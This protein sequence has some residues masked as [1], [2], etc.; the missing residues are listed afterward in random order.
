MGDQPQCQHVPPTF[1]SACAKIRREA[2]LQLNQLGIAV[3]PSLRVL[4]S[5][6]HSA[7]R[8]GCRPEQEAIALKFLEKVQSLNFA[9]V[10]EL[11]DVVPL[12]ESIGM[13]EAIVQLC[14]AK[15]DALV[16]PPLLLLIC[17]PLL[18]CTSPRLPVGTCPFT[19]LIP[20]SQCRQ[21]QRVY[22]LS[23]EGGCYSGLGTERFAHGSPVDSLVSQA[24]GQGEGN[25]HSHTQAP[26]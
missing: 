15:A 2:G 26:E 13:C 18:S 24:A 17:L 4:H 20:G 8:A 16:R 10:I 9:A 23:R 5:V 1:M 14:E 22:L 19:I 25:L 6:L 21:L 7:S 3:G 11:K 12:L